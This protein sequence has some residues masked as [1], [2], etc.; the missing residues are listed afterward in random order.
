M[1]NEVLSRLQTMLPPVYDRVGG[2]CKADE[3][4]YEVVFHQRTLGLELESGT[5]GVNAV[6]KSLE[7]PIARKQIFRGSLVC[8]VNNVW[9]IG[10]TLEDIEL[11]IVHEATNVGPPLCVRFRA[12]RRLRDEYLQSYEKIVNNRDLSSNTSPSREE[13]KMR[14]SNS[15]LRAN[16]RTR[17]SLGTLNVTVE[18]CFDLLQNASFVTVSVL[19]TTC[20]SNKVQPSESPVWNEILKWKHYDIKKYAGEKAL[21]KVWQYNRFT[22]NTCVGQVEVV[23]PTEL[24]FEKKYDLILKDGKKSV[25]NF[26]C[27]IALPVELKT[28]KKRTNCK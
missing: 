16:D 1:P 24:N 28:K 18:S 20:T 17:K 7:T 15:S 22:S 8:S 9:L 19:N 4:D 11:N 25:G 12:K 14:T 23:L 13:I 21:F 10:A 3:F 27:T 2:V 6:V 5:G 26:R